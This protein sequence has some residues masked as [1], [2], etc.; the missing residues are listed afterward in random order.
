[1][2]YLEEKLTSLDRS[3]LWH[4]TLKVDRHLDDETFKYLPNI[5]PES[6]VDTWHNTQVRVAELACLNPVNYDTCINSCVCYVGPH[7]ALQQCPY[8]G[9][10]RLNAR[11][12]ARKR[13]QYVPLIPR[14]VGYYKNRDMA[15][16]LRYRAEFDTLRAARAPEDHGRVEDIFDGEHY[17]RLRTRHVVVDQKTYPHRFFESPRDIALAISTDGFAP[18]KRRSKT[19]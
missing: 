15:Q 10:A 17:Q 12:R 19:C 7:A 14:L 11:G 3:T 13:F 16:K 1:M 6:A 5:F 8:C 2:L 4:Y 18:F 9:E